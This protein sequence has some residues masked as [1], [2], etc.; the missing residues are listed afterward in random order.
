LSGDRAR[1]HA[2]T[3]APVGRGVFH[4]LRERRE[5]N[6]YRLVMP[7]PTQELY[8]AYVDAERMRQ[9]DEAAELRARMLALPRAERLVLA[10]E[11]I[12]RA[13]DSH[14]V[15]AALLASVR[16]GALPVPELAGVLRALGQ[17]R[18]LCTQPWREAWSL[19]KRHIGTNGVDPILYDGLR[20]MQPAMIQHGSDKN[21]RIAID[22][23]LWFAT[24]LPLDEGQCASAVIAHDL[25]ALTATASA[26]WTQLLLELMLASNAEP[27]ERVIQKARA[28]AETIGVDG[29]RESAKRWLVALSER[30]SLRFSPAG[31]DAT[32]AV[33]WLGAQLRDSEIDAAIVRLVDRRWPRS[34][35]VDWSPR[36]DRFVGALVYA[37]GMQ[38]PTT[39]RPIVLALE[40]TFGRTTAKYVISRVL[41][42]TLA[43]LVTA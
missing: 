41:D 19:A 18:L 30:E 8:E 17:S 26:R 36:H 15:A 13:H 43:P 20:A 22:R 4:A 24:H 7:E 6:V 16:R 31:A 5:K 9:K 28:S 32:R 40:P 10:A 38:E 37:V 25:R 33:V 29:V 23:V 2:G 21:A 11:I 12:A 34:R 42:S 27:S 35:A 39:S 1:A 3:I 14:G